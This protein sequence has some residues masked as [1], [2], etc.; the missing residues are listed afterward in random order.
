[1]P[2]YRYDLRIAGVTICM[3]T[4]QP[5]RLEDAFEPFLAEEGADADVSAVFCPVR[6]LPAVSGPMIGKGICHRVY[7]REKGGYTRRFFREPEGLEPYAQ[8]TYDLSAGTVRV[9]YLDSAAD[10]VSEMGNSFWHL[11]VEALMIRKNKL[12]LHAACV[13]TPL[14][15]LLFSGPSGIGKS[16]QA[17]LWCKHRGAEQI[18]GDR[19]ILSKGEEGWLAWGSPYAGSSRCHRNESCPVRAIVMLRQGPACRIRRLG[20]AEAFRA[21]YSGLTINSWD[22]A[23]VTTACDLT[24]D[25]IAGVPVYELE[26]TPDE[27]AVRLLEHELGKGAK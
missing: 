25:L 20:A 3:R 8:G 5:L 27:Q 15:G 2:E 10:C 26:C 13:D 1:M 4:C 14:G 24:M 6:E 17:A 12:C 23:F 19:P 18:N 21:V 11:G 7:S 16:T 9:D 22:R